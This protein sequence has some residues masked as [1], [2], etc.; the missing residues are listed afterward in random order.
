MKRQGYREQTITRYARVL[1][2]LSRTASL[3][4]GEEV[5]QAIADR[6]WTDGTKELACDAYSLLAKSKG[7]SF[8]RPRYKGTEQLPFIPLEQEIDAL[9][10]GTGP[11]TSAV[12]QLLKETAARIGEAL[13]LKWSDVDFERCTITLTPEKNSKPRQFKISPKLV[14]MLNRL[15]KKNTFLFGG[16]SADKFRRNYQQ[17]RNRLVM[18]L[19]NPR[20]HQIKLH[21]FRHWKAT[22]EYNRTKDILYVMGFLGHKSISNT[23]KY[24]QLVDWKTEEYVCKIAK[25]LDEASNLIE[26]GFEYVTEMADIKLFRKRK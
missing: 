6:S 21:T 25:S 7:F 13:G 23:L 22:Y 19:A 11:K 16:S 15:E 14:S 17:Q 18:K 10:S 1:R 9:I 5:K 3:V 4:D 2:N 26:A 12:L 8:E 20:L 24:T